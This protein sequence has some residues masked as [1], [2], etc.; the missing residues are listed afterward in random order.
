MKK[1]P[2]SVMVIVVVVVFL[3]FLVNGLS[4]K[5]TTAD[6]GDKAKD[7]SLKD[8]N[9]KAYKLS[10]YRGKII[11]MN[12]FTTWCGPCLDEAPELEA[13]G[14]EYKDAQF[15]VLAKGETTNRVKNYIQKNNSKLIYLLDTKEGTAKNY[16]VV[17]QPETIIIDGK[18]VIRKRI[19]G[20]TTKK[21]LIDIVEKLH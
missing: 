17:G 15:F 14:S 10:D 18:G 11:V 5:A 6:L 9:G 3:G 13:F 16:N 20:P 12:F 21:K 19:T 8:V 1:N 4:G 2:I 7:F